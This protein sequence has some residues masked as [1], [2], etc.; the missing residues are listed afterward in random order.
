MADKESVLE[1]VEKM[2]I[3]SEQLQDINDPVKESELNNLLVLQNFT[4]ARKSGKI[5]F[6]IRVVHHFVVKFARQF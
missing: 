2:K 1:H 4:I 3:I 6:R 5:L